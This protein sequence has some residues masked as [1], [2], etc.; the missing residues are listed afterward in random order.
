MIERC[1]ATCEEPEGEEINTNRCG[2]RDMAFSKFDVGTFM[3][4]LVGRYFQSEATVLE[5][6]QC[7]SRDDCEGGL[8]PPLNRDTTAMP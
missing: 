4:N 6:D 8:M 2:C 3:L 1:L 7:L 5:A